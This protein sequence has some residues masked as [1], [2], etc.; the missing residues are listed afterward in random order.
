M[1]TNGFTR[2]KIGETVVRLLTI[3]L[4]VITICGGTAFAQTLE[5][6]PAGASLTVQKEIII[7]PY[8]DSVRV[9]ESQTYGRLPESGERYEIL[10]YFQM[11]IEP[12]DNT[13]R[14][15]PGTKFTVTKVENLS[16]EQLQRF[17]VFVDN[18][19]VKQIDIYSF[20]GYEGAATIMIQDVAPRFGGVFKVELPEIE[21]F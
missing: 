21:E 14:I 20:D 8:T 7:P 18:P 9:Y 19:K 5:L 17:L 15:S 2:I 13:R 16:E 11:D 1:P 12:H 6:L 4:F 3:S 10:E